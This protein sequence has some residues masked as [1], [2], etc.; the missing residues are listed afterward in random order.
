MCV[1]I[2]VAPNQRRQYKSYPQTELLSPRNAGNFYL[3]QSVDEAEQPSGL[4]QG[5]H[6]KSHPKT[7]RQKG[8][9]PLY[10]FWPRAGIRSTPSDSIKSA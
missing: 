1:P 10:E 6:H 4:Q 3:P 7:Q 8:K 2:N 5:I 9:W